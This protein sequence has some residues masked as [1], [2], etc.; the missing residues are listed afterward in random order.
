MGAQV[1][2]IFDVG[3]YDEQIQRAAH[4]LK[5]GRIVVLPTETV[6][7]A[8]AILNQPDGLLRLRGLPPAAAPKPLTIHLAKREDARRFLGPTSDLAGRMMKKLW[9]GPVALMFDVPEPRR[10]EVAQDIGVPVTELYDGQSITLRCP[11]HIVAADVI[12]QSGGPVVLRKSGDS[13]ARV[14]EEWLG[15]ID[16]IL[17]A[18]PTRYSKP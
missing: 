16:L 5:D 7:G 4:I 13:S 2:Q 3:D 6:Y 14:A 8:A 15:K 18:G 10:E 9:P 11:D 17:D 12:G 1:V